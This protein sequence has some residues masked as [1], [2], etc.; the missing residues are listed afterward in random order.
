MQPRNQGFLV[1]PIK[2]PTKQSP[3]LPRPKNLCLHVSSTNKQKIS[4][5]LGFNIPNTIDEPSSTFSLPKSGSAST[6]SHSK[7]YFCSVIFFYNLIA[8]V[9]VIENMKNLLF[10]SV[11]SLSRAESTR[12]KL[13]SS[14]KNRKARL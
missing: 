8:S 14:L 3:I 7:T 1:S 11:R 4:D 10:F 13:M 6:A 12:M 9:K 5:L 2:S